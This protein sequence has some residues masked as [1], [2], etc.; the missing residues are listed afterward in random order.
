MLD[1]VGAS[2]RRGLTLMPDYATSEDVV[3]SVRDAVAA[4]AR[5]V[6]DGQPTTTISGSP[7]PWTSSSVRVEG[8][9][10]LRTLDVFVVDSA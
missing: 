7:P 8:A 5:V 9:H 6:A 10:G 1:G 4:L 3:S 2:G